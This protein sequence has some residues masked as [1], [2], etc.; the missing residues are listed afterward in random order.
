MSPSLVR[1]FFK[2]PRKVLS[3]LNFSFLS[4]TYKTKQLIY[5]QKIYIPN[6]S[7]ML[8]HALTSFKIPFETRSTNFEVSLRVTFFYQLHRTSVFGLCK[9]RN[10]I[11]CREI[12]LTEKKRVWLRKKHRALSIRGQWRLIAL[13]QSRPNNRVKH[14]EERGGGVTDM[15]G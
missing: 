9:G 5:K 14:V 11:V 12:S 15:M 6:R 3:T 7:G 10:L 1:I 4:L 13:K 8:L 2:T